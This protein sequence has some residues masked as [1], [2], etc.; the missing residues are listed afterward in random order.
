M[1][2]KSTL[3]TNAIFYN[4]ELDQLYLFEDKHFHK[5]EFIGWGVVWHYI[6]E[7]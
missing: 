6:G 5:I 7:L 2:H 4:A 3:L 1:T